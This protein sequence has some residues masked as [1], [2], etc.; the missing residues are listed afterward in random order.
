[1]I[2]NQ[3]Y[4]S[5][6]IALGLLLT[7]TEIVFAD[8]PFPASR[9]ARARISS[10]KVLFRPP[11]NDRR[12]LRTVGAG[13]RGG[14]CSQDLTA[15]SSP[16]SISNKLPLLALVPPGN[17]GL[18]VADVPSSNVGLTV[19]E[20]PTF[21][22]YLPQTSAKKVVLT[23]QSEDNS[24]HFQ[25]S[26]P[27]PSAAGIVSLQPPANAPP[28]K[29]GQTYQWAVVLVC[30]ERPS[31]NDP[32]IAAWVKRVSPAQSIPQSTALSQAAWYGEQGLWYDMLTALGKEL[33][34]QPTNP[35]LTDIW[36]NVLKSEGLEIVAMEPLRQE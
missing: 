28:L 34:S 36:A 7:G 32:A 24:S 11:A 21:W 29:I 10:T 26:F 20:R 22:M 33:R 15:A 1:M 27:V 12:P 14:Q 18:T 19:A 4:F 6:L 8:T 16:S 31:P 23:L 13:S 25:W 2:L 35:D 9:M 30:G 5:C 3:R 17:V